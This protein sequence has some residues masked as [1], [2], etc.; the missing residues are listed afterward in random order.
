MRQ[1][2]ALLRLDLAQYRELVTFTQYGSEIDKAA[3]MQLSRGERMVQILKQDQYSPLPLSRQVM[4]ILA[5]TR[6]L[7]DDLPADSIRLFEAGFYKFIEENFLNIDLEIQTKKILSDELAQRLEKAVL[8][9]KAE[10]IK[11]LQK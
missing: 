4:I 1:V 11:G 9:F 3:Q 10:F 7:L 8:E 6:G 5:G 2:A